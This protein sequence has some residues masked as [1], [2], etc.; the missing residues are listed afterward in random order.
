MRL[1]VRL[2]R[3]LDRM[4]ELTS[5]APFVGMV[6]QQADFEG[7]DCPKQHVLARAVRTFWAACLNVE[8]G[9]AESNHLLVDGFGVWLYWCLDLISGTAGDFFSKDVLESAC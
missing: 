7:S 4:S 2:W 9:S 8:P 1:E 6:D 3:R 5:F